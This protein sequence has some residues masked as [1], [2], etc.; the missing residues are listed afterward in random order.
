MLS[1]STFI[2]IL[3][4][5]EGTVLMNKEKIKQLAVFVVVSA[6]IIA[7]AA[8]IFKFIIKILLPVLLVLFAVGFVV[9]LFSG[10]GGKDE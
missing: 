3:K 8:V 2:L 7:L 9:M 5:P 4:D 1:E 6:V 10:R